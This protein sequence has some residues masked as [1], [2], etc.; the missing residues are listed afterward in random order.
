M[1]TNNHKRLLSTLLTVTAA[2]A[3][4]F[5]T[6]SCD[7]NI[8]RDT[9]VGNMSISFRVDGERY[10]CAEKDFL[11]ESP[12]RISF[13]DETFLDFHVDGFSVNNVEKEGCLTFT[14][15]ATNPIKTGKKYPLR[16]YSGDASDRV[17]EPPVYF[18]EFNG[19]RSVEGW[20]KFRTIDTYEDDENFV[21]ISG[22]FEFIGRNAEGRTI[23]V[24]YGTFDGLY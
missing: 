20:I 8:F 7:R 15:S 1:K 16:Y 13:Y 18:A 19:Y 5:V 3:A 9:S 11:N 14:I 6:C 22:N 21:V 10:E 17:A 12:M 24:K 2:L 23:N 4:A